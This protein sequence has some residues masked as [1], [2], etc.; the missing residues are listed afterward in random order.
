MH[1]RNFNCNY[2]DSSMSKYDEKYIYI[3]I[4]IILYNIY[5]ICFTIVKLGHLIS[6]RNIFMKKVCRKSA[7]TTSPITLLN[8]GK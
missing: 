2:V 5:I 3:Y 1:S 6:I 4:Y 8:F 7:L